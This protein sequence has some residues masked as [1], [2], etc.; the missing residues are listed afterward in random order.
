MCGGGGPVKNIFI[1]FNPL[2]KQL[3]EDCRSKHTKQ[4][5]LREWRILNK[6]KI[7]MEKIGGLTYRAG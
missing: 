4:A 1:Q 2:R 7:I 5:K 3:T 6:V